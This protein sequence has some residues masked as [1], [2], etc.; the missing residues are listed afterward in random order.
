ME[1]AVVPGG[2]EAASAGKEDHARSVT[3]MFA[4]PLAG[5]RFHIHGVN[6]P[7][8]AGGENLA[9]IRRGIGRENGGWKLDFLGQLELHGNFF[10][11]E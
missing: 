5:A 4:D 10:K 3:L 11:G 7:V 6:A 1:R 2:N 9:A 8:Q